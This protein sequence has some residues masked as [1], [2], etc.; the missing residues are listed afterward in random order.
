[1]ELNTVEKDKQRNEKQDETA[2]LFKNGSSQAVRLPKAYRFEGDKVFIRQE[3]D[4]VILSPYKSPTE[5]LIES[6]AMFTDDFHLERN[7][8]TRVEEREPFDP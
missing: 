7:Q 2:K 4:N 8:P 6:L 3:G 1:M 5:R